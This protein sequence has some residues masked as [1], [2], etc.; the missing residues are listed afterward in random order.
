MLS[1]GARRHGDAQPRVGVN[2]STSVYGRKYGVMIWDEA[3]RVRT[4]G[5]LFT[6]A[7]ELRKLAG[8]CVALTA[9]PVLTQVSVSIRINI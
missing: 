8:C 5:N 9:T 3:H 6:A 2:T 4:L 1:T 7:R